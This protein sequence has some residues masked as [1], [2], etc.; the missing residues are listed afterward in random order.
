[1]NKDSMKRAVAWTVVAV[2]G[3]G[4]AGAFSVSVLA[5]DNYTL[6]LRDANTRVTD[7]AKSVAA[8]EN[9]ILVGTD[10]LADA[11]AANVDKREK[12]KSTEGFI[13]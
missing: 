4:L 9:R 13:K 12:L 3:I 5:G 8:Q 2:L 6:G 1:M 10:D 11:E 7:T